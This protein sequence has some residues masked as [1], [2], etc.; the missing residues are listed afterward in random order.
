M[1][2]RIVQI[3]STGCGLACVAMIAGRSY[4]QVKKK[5]TRLGIVGRSGPFYTLSKDLRELLLSY[6]IS[7]GVGRKIKKWESLPKKAILAINYQEKSNHWHWVVFVRVN[8]A[9]FYVLDPR[10]AV[11]SERRTD[12]GR[13]QLHSY[14]PVSA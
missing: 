9:E 10:K 4:E 11:R 14:I 5:A 6:N 13:M 1:I 12:F 7:C 3:D 2:Q 8:K